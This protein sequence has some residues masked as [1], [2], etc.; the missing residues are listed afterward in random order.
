[1]ENLSVSLSQSTLRASFC[2]F[3]IK[4]FYDFVFTVFAVQSFYEEPV[5]WSHTVNS[6]VIFK[7][8][9]RNKK[10]ELQWTQNGFAIAIDRVYTGNSRYSVIGGQ[11]RQG[12]DFIGKYMY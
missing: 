7:C 8:S 5:S 9:I 12:N 11:S 4:S 10:G 1:M 6:T 3:C 2:L